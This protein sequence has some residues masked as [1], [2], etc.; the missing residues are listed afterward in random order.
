MCVD[1]VRVHT[2]ALGVGAIYGPAHLDVVGNMDPHGD[3]SLCEKFVGRH[4]PHWASVSARL[5][6]GLYPCGRHGLPLAIGR[7]R[8]Q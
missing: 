7:Q 5:G 2:P 8:S 1:I 4:Q 6:M 3:A